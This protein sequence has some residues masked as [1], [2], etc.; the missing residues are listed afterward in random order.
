LPWLL[1][2]GFSVLY[3]PADR[4]GV[5]YW[6]LLLPW[7]AWAFAG[8]LFRGQSWNPRL[9]LLVSAVFALS[10]LFLAQFLPVRTHGPE[11]LALSLLQRKIR[12]GRVNRVVLD[13]RPGE[14]DFTLKDKYVWYTDTD[15][16][17]VFA[18]SPIPSSKPE[19]AY[20]VYYPSEERKNELLQKG[21]CWKE[22]VSSRAV[23][24]N[25]PL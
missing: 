25:C 5:Q 22:L 14:M 17:M 10:V 21:W 24:L 9:P 15:V 16:E 12:E 4:V 1:L 20:V 11:D 23:F 18:G 2:L 8:V 19:T 7:I 13:L 6:V 3:A